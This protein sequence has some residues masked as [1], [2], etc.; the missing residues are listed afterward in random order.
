MLVS[1]GVR[2]SDLYTALGDLDA[3]AADSAEIAERMTAFLIAE[4]VVAPN[5]TD[6]VLGAE[7]GYPPGPNAD[8]FTEFP[9][10]R[11]LWTNGAE[12]IAGPELHLSTSDELVMTCPHCGRSTAIEFSAEYWPPMQRD[13]FGFADGDGAIAC[14]ECGERAPI[15]DVAWQDEAVIAAYASVVFWNW[16][17]LS[18]LQAALEQHLGHR[19]RMQIAKF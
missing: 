8:A 12:I 7:T 16:G 5:R 1:Y 18:A 3:T 19:F 13:L 15:N 6:C 2:M 10:D 17:D 11:T 14:P 9:V 4:G